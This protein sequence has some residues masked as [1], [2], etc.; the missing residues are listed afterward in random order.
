MLSGSG[1]IVGRVVD[2][3]SDVAIGDAVVTLVLNPASAAVSLHPQRVTVDGRG[4]F[5]FHD[6][7]KGT[8]TLNV[9]A[10]GYLA[11]GYGQHRP[12]GTTL[13][14]E[15]G[16][17]QHVSD[18]TIRLW[19]FAAIG[20][21]VVDE[22]GDPLVGV[23]VRILQESRIAGPRRVMPKA[24]AVTDDRGAFRFSSLEPGDY[25]VAVPS[26]AASSP[27]SDGRGSLYAT[28]FYPS[29]TTPSQAEII[30]LGSGEERSGIDVTRRLVRT[31]SV[32]GS[33]WGP[34][35]PASNFALRLVPAYTNDWADDSGF[36]AAR[37]LTDGR[38]AF[39]FPG[40]P[41]G[42]Y[43]LEGIASSA[44]TEPN[45]PT[46]EPTAAR[47]P[48]NLAVWNETALWGRTAVSVGEA[49]VV[50]LLL[51]LREGLTMSGRLRFVG[52]SQPPTADQLQQLSISLTSAD[53]R[54][55]GP[56][57][58]GRIAADGQFTIRGYLPGQYAVNV[59]SPDQPWTLMSMTANG[60]DLLR[61]PLAL[62]SDVTGAVITFTDR[63]TQLAGAVQ[64][65]TAPDQRL[66]VVTFPADYAAAL[67]NGMLG[68]RSR[69]MPLS[70]ARQFTIDG[71]PAGDYLVAAIPSDLAA[72]WMDADL[73]ALIARQATHVSLTDG[74]RKT[75]DPRVVVIR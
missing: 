23:S 50:G 68:R 57:P 29:A 62:D 49:D 54:S 30:A 1:L 73:V 44:V 20:G 17:G 7:P 13:P 31:V 59:P 39:T 3:S 22:F 41:P 61:A 40:V 6:L 36:E 33:A 52:R 63:P 67:D 64:R 2:A 55:R 35:D 16:E 56:E 26:T 47:P 28:T 38:G 34:D 65:S 21:T 15:L 5:L 11:G 51:V 58:P 48:V 8:V 19:K 9:S 14:I 10:D 32:S 42:Q 43:L 60:R 37:A 74:D 72:N 69:E 53:G 18:V 46:S 27:T 12:N 71:L 75:V 24:K 66:M 4:R 45:R 25:I 70:A